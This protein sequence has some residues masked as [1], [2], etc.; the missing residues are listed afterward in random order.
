MYELQ[1]DGVIR[2]LH[3]YFRHFFNEGLIYLKDTEVMPRKV[4]QSRK[5][6]EGSLLKGMYWSVFALHL[7]DN[8]FWYDVVEVSEESDQNDTNARGKTEEMYA[9]FDDKRATSADR[10]SDMGDADPSMRVAGTS[11]RSIDREFPRGSR[12]HT[13]MSDLETAVLSS[14]EVDTLM[15]F[16]KTCKRE[17]VV[18]DYMLMGFAN[19]DDRRRFHP[20]ISS[21]FLALSTYRVIR[22]SI[23]SPDSFEYAGHMSWIYQVDELLCFI[24]MLYVPSKG[25]YRKSLSSVMPESADIRHTASAV[26]ATSSALRLSG[27]GDEYYRDKMATWIDIDDVTNHII[28]HFNEDGGISLWVPSESHCGAAFCAVATLTVLGTMDRLPRKKLVELKGWLLKSLTQF[29]GVSGRVGK[30][31]DVCYSFWLLATLR[32]LKQSGLNVQLLRHREMMRFIQRCQTPSGG[33]SPYPC[34]VNDNPQADPFHSFAALLAITLLEED[35][36]QIETSV[37]QKLI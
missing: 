26:L 23:N 4:M 19:S 36:Q 12:S 10:E 11:E 21:T 16:L 2:K 18:D 15:R 28:Q 14:K 35:R 22:D 17:F 34:D 7:M 6:Y 20:N 32:L 5:G 1:R 8:A 27:C 9:G 24:K 31:E 29:G 25:Y 37:L 13:Y 33:I 30:T 3:A